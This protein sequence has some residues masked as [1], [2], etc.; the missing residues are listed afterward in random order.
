[1]DDNNKTEAG[2]YRAPPITE[3]LVELRF[4][5]SRPWDSQLLA[6]VGTDQPIASES[7]SVSKAVGLLTPEG[8]G[9]TSPDSSTR[10]SVMGGAR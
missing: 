1:M 2:G 7:P 3:A 8:D 6:A 5:G 10:A 4:Q 9:R